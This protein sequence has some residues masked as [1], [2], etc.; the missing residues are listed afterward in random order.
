MQEISLNTQY[1]TCRCKSISSPWN[2]L[3][4]WP[5][6]NCN[7]SELQ[8]KFD[9][10]W[11]SQQLRSVNSC[12]R[13]IACAAEDADPVVYT[14]PPF[15]CTISY[16]EENIRVGEPFHASQPSLSIDGFTDPS[17]CDRFCLGILSNVNRPQPVENTRR[18][19]GLFLFFNADIIVCAITMAALCCENCQ[20][21]RN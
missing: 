1:S 16:Y 5:V 19:I 4:K 3:F 8:I 9:Q 11:F 17:S 14:E 18:H 13:V 10:W 20:Q 7:P 21:V 6:C 2:F 12:W 15:W